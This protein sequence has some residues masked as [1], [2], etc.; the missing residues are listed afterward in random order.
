M[1]EALTSKLRNRACALY[2]LLSTDF[3]TEITDVSVFVVVFL[4]MRDRMG[5]R[6]SGGV[7]ARG[8]YYKS[9]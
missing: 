1:T 5:N 3:H 9:A 2:R 4:G 6:D 8:C 7:S